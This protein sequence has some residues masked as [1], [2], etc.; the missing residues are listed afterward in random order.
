M[1]PLARNTRGVT[2]VNQRTLINMAYQKSNHTNL[3]KLTNLRHWYIIPS[4]PNTYITVYQRTLIKKV[5]TIW[6][7]S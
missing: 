2:N 6:E 7:K 3:T 1:E 4:Q 5:I